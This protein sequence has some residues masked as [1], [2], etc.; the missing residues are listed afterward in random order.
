MSSRLLV[1][2][3]CGREVG[4]EI[5]SIKGVRYLR[6]R[7]PPRSPLV[8][9]RARASKTGLTLDGLL[10]QTSNRRHLKVS[11]SRA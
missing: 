11:T 3:A 8:T 10:Y 7:S 9:F 5:A 4:T 6:I 1:N 2:S